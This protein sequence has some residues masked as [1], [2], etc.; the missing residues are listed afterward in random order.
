MSAVAIFLVSI[1]NELVRKDLNFSSDSHF[2]S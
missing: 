1:F 2:L